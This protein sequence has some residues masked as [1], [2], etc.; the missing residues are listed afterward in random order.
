LSHSIFLNFRNFLNEAHQNFELKD[1]KG[2]N[3]RL[4][5]KRMVN[6]WAQLVKLKY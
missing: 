1:V 2:N 3:I 4:I 6:F 5:E